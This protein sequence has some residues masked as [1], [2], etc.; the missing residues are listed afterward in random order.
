[1]ITW[2]KKGDAY[3]G[4]LHYS[5]GQSGNVVV[6]GGRDNP[7]GA[8]LVF[9]EEGGTETKTLPFAEAKDL[10]HPWDIMDVITMQERAFG[11]GMLPGAEE[12]L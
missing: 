4:S 8:A 10:L 3:I 12:V 9:P 1:M 5:D 7:K 2:R 6:V 11:G